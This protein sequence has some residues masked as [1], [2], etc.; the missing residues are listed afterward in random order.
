M[1]YVDDT[2]ILMAIQTPKDAV[3]LQNELNLIYQWANNNHMK[4][5]TSKFQSFHYGGEKAHQSQYLTPGNT[6]VQHTDD[7]QDSGVII[8]RDASFN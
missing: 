3:T 5:N 7:I 2:K 1:S 8:S 6:M 4:F